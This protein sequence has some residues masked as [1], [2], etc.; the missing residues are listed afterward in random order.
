MLGQLADY[1]LMVIPSKVPP[2]PASRDIE[3]LR[4]IT[5]AADIPVGPAVSHYVWIPR[6]SRRMAV[7]APPITKQGQPF[8]DEIA[9]VAQSV[10]A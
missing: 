1:P 6:R 3:R 5:Q 4:R 8:A 7:S 2:V 9:A 10:I